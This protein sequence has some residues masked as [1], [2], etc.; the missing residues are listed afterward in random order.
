MNGFE[1]ESGGRKGNDIDALLLYEILKKYKN[2]KKV[3]FKL[4]GK[5]T[6]HL[7]TNKTSNF[8]I[9]TLCLCHRSSCIQKEMIYHISSHNNRAGFSTPM[10]SH[11]SRVSL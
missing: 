8:K 3:F 2:K 6:Q 4:N 9:A 7:Q 10:A 1:C 11:H 5:F